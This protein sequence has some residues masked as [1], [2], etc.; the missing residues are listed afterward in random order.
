[1]TAQAFRPLADAFD[2]KANDL[3]NAQE[4][5]SDELARRRDSR[6]ARVFQAR[7][8]SIMGD[9]MVERGAVAS[10][11]QMHGHRRRLGS[12]DITTEVI[13]RIDERLG[14]GSRT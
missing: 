4:A 10:A 3:R 11:R 6:A 12:I 2:T 7:S 9:Y 13:A 1:M 14:D 8:R 5:K